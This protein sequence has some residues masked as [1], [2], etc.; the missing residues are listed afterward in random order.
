MLKKVA[1]GPPFFFI[2]FTIDRTSGV[3]TLVG[4]SVAI[5][6]W[7]GGLA[8]V[9]NATVI[10]DLTRNGFVDFDDLTILLSNWNKDGDTPGNFVDAT[11]TPIDFDDLT[12]LLANWTGPDP[13]GSAEA[14]LGEAAVPEPST[15]VLAMIAAISVCCFRRR[16]RPSNIR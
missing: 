9:P 1:L 3:A 4:P 7:S 14:A 15:L 12:V 8:F 16:R 11:G 6:G 10:P 13:D 2:N 5:S